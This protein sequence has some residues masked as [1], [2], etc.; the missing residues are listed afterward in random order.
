MILRTWRGWTR[1]EDAGEYERLIREEIF[2]EIE[3]EAGDGFLGAELLRREN[4]TEVEFLTL[5]RFVS[6]DPI[7]RLTGD[8]LERA[9]VPAKARELLRRY[10]ARVRHY[11]A[12]DQ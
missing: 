2:P 8:D 12:A 6:V 3:S 7:R 10:D 11:T 4:G 9:Y 5:L 1:R